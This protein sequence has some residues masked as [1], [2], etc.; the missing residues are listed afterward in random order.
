MTSFP[1]RFSWNRL[2]GAIVAPFLTTNG[3]KVLS[4][5]V[6]DDDATGAAGSAGAG[7]LLDD[8][9]LLAAVF[10]FRNEESNERDLF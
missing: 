2:I 8:A 3:L 10:G 5:S 4:K 7:F 9:V 1:F 6:S